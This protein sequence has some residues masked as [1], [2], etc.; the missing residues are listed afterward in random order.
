MRIFSW[1]RPF[2]CLNVVITFSRC[3]Y[4]GHDQPCP[5]WGKSYLPPITRI[6]LSFVRIASAWNTKTG[7]LLQPPVHMMHGWSLQPLREG[8]L[9]H[10][11]K[12]ELTI[13]ADHRGQLL[14]TF[15]LLL[16]QALQKSYRKPFLSHSQSRGLFQM[17]SIPGAGTGLGWLQPIRVFHTLVIVTGLGMRA[18][19]SWRQCVGRHVWPSRRVTL[20]FSSEAAAERWP[21]P[22]MV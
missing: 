12:S 19:S 2:P 13:E 17:N 15:P 21:P 5:L 16:E 4:Q 1:P 18:W 7:I 3:G 9:I 11:S 14:S 20:S 6:L 22:L 10:S 8:L